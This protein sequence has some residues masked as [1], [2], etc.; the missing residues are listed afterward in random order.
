M[1]GIGALVLTYNREALLS[2]CLQAILTQ[3]R[4]PDEVIVLDNA[5]TDGTVALL[6]YGPFPNRERI[7][8]YR[9]ERN[10]GCAGGFDVLVRIGWQRGLDWIW[11]MDDDV[12]PDPTALEALLAAYGE[13]FSRPE[14][15]SFLVSAARSEAG[16]P[17]NVPE[18]DLRA[19]WLHC[20][21]WADRL[22]RGLVRLRWSTFNSI[23]IPRCTLNRIGGLCADLYYAGEDVDFTLRATEVAPGYLVGSSKVMHLRA[24][25]GV[26]SALT[27]STRAQIALARYYYR[28][29]LYLRRRHYSRLR[30]AS[31]AGRC[32][33]EALLALAA[34]PQRLRRAASILGGAVAG[35]WFAPRRL[36]LD[37]PLPADLSELRLGA[38]ASQA[39]AVARA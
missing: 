24:A 18:I 23:L 22:D 14:E 7:R 31:F 9:L 26:F 4:L 20:A 1:G 30:V 15:V 2:R 37:R 5:S 36:P 39:G 25:D 10:V 12:I 13:N 38:A 35:L 27:R 6:R 3:S 21:N 28:N 11:C 17:S 16:A 34:R 19:P 33:L 8:A 32:C 29:T